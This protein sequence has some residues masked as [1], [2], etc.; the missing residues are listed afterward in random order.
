MP[1]P[2]QSLL[3]P[4]SGWEDVSFSRRLC[5]LHSDGFLGPA[6]CSGSPGFTRC[7]SDPRTKL[8]NEI[9]FWLF[10]VPSVRL[11]GLRA[12]GGG[13]A[14]LS[15]TLPEPFPAPVECRKSP[16]PFFSSVCRVPPA[17]QVTRPLSEFGGRAGSPRL[18]Q[19]FSVRQGEFTGSPALLSDLQAGLAERGLRLPLSSSQP[20]LAGRRES[21]RVLLAFSGCRDGLGER[22]GSLGSL[23][24]CS[25]CQE[26]R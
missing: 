24:C 1:R 25:S 8:G 15:L 19:L 10:L 16:R 21:P 23:L 3:V 22:R 18:L 20:G 13:P 6:R 2:F 12:C 9:S 17:C 4:F 26:S 11:P 14:R 5:Q 7:L